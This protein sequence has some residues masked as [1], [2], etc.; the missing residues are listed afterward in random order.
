MKA[1][2]SDFDGTLFD[3]AEAN[4]LAY[5]DSFRKNGLTLTKED[6]NRFFGLRF[7]SLMNALNVPYEL[8]KKIKIDKAEF[9]LERI[10][11][12][13]VNPN[14]NLLRFI[15]NE[16]NNGIKTAIAST[17]SACNVKAILEHFRKTHLF[18]VVLTGEDVEHGKPDPDVY[19]K[20]LEKLN[21]SAEDAI[22]FEDT[23]IGMLAAER[24]KINCIN[25]A[26]RNI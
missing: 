14:I 19:L 9:Y 24:A 1:I 20:A 18:D 23:P 8:H 2:I 17:A 5:Q 13:Y 26:I 7:D 6:Y 25:I 11:Y 4:F 15:E 21:V 16:H 22:A 3:T 10:R 12:N